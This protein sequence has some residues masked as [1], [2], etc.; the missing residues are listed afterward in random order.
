MR[1]NGLATTWKAAWKRPPRPPLTE[2]ATRYYR[3]SD[4]YEANPGPYNLAAY[5]YLREIMDAFSDPDVERLTIVA[6]TQVGKTL[7]VLVAMAYL[8]DTD[9]APA[10]ICTPDQTST[11]E[12]RDRFYAN[13]LETPKLR[14]RVPPQRQW[15]TRHIDMRQNRIY[16]AWA[17]SRQR[18]RGR[19]CRYVFMSEV[20]VYVRTMAGDPMKTGPERTKKFFRKKITCESTPVGEDSP[21]SREYEAGDQ[22]AGMANARTAD[23]TRRPG[24]FHSP[25]GNTRAAAGSWGMSAK[26]ASC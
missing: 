19:P 18:L 11:I 4:Q 16:M 10:L 13:A 26:T 7:F 24:S 23:C 14:D 6:S 21:I 15:N 3:L 12:F 17:G 5:P 1:T 9:P 20:D 22:H 2:W 8:S 25:R